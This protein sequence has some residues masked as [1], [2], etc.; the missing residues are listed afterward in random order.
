MRSKKISLG[1]AGVAVAAVLAGG[2]ARAQ[3]DEWTFSGTFYLFASDTT[4]RIGPVETEL[5]FS[6][7]LENLDLAFMGAVE[8]SN[9]TWSLI[10][11]YMY[12]DLTFRG[13]S[14]VQGFTGSETSVTTQILTGYA[15]YRVFT[16]G[17]TNVDI[18]GGLRWFDTS[19][20]IALTGGPVMTPRSLK[21]NW[22][23]PLLMVRA[24]TRFGDRW[25]GA[26]LADYG[27]FFSDSET[28]Q[29]TLNVGYELTDRW[30]LR[31]GYRYIDVEQTISGVDYSFTQ[32]GPVLGA[33]YRF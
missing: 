15:A 8:A 1:L 27:G 13:G 26:I 14:P 28:S 12:T 24:Q 30:T 20:E 7:A 32:S 23:D 16:Y 4:T 19:T 9:G 22:V 25:V 21:D 5:S 11:D 29:L 2:A 33:S 18:G 31:A 3:G 17:T 10:A 6:D